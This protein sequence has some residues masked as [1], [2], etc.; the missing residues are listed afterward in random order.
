MKI[1]FI[2]LSLQQFITETTLNIKTNLLNDA[3][4]CACK[5]T[6]TFLL[7]FNFRRKKCEIK[8]S[9]RGHITK[10]IYAVI[11]EKRRISHHFILHPHM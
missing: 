5:L 9:S 11:T 2:C 1:K 7:L 8:T 4:Y 3:V 10:F 6:N